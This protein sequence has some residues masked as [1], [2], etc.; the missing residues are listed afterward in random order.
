VSPWLSLARRKLAE[1]GLKLLLIFNKIL[2]RLGFRRVFYA[3][4]FTDRYIRDTFFPDFSYHGVM[5]EVGCATPTLLS[6][7]QHFRQNGWRCIGI[8]PNPEFVQLHRAAGNEVFT[9]AAADYDGDDVDFLVVEASDDYSPGVLSAHSYSALGLKESFQNHL[10][11]AKASFQQ[12]HIKVSVRRLSRILAEH[13]P[14]IAQIDLLS[15]DVEGYELEVMRGLDLQQIPVR[16]IV[17]ENLFDDPAYTDYMQ[18]QGYR[19]H[20]R[21]HYNYIYV[22]SH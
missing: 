7:S 8:E 18:S 3:E 22:K 4:Y 9:Y 20:S 11:L 16:V 6:M 19:L 10:N 13:C 17:L 12:R 1:I 14:E 5:V 21:V 15:V 2:T